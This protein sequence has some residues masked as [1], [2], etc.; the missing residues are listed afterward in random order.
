LN[1][2]DTTLINRGVL[3]CQMSELG[4]YGDPNHFAV[5]FLEVCQ[6][7]V[8]GKY[9]RWADKGEVEGVKEQH[10]VLAEKAGKFD[11]AET[12]VW[13]D[14]VSRKVRGFLGDQGTITHE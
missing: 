11:G 5:S 4:I 8:E 3:P 7:L 6:P 14:C 12:I 9:F 1:V 10:H 13:H 2:P